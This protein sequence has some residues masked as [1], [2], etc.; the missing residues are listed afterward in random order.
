MSF[1]GG[2]ATG[3]G[4][5]SWTAP[6]RP[7][8]TVV[9]YICGRSYGTASLAIHTKACAKRFLEEEA[10][11]PKGQRRA[12][13]EPPSTELLAE[14]AAAQG[15][16]A[17]AGFGGGGAAAYKLIEAHNEAAFRQYN[18]VTLVACALCGRTFS[19]PDRLKIHNRSCTPDQPA[20][21]VG[22]KGVGNGGAPTAYKVE[23]DNEGA[24]RRGAALVGDEDGG[25]EDG[26][27]EAAAAAVAAAAAAA[28]AAAS[29]A[30]RRQGGGAGGARASAASQRSPPVVSRRAAEGKEEGG[31]G[32]G[33]GGGAP[34]ASSRGGGA[35]AAASAAATGAEEDAAWRESLEE[36]FALLRERLDESA[37]RAAREAAEIRAEIEELVEE[38]ARR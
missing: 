9:C 31:G 37:A 14:L 35:A 33:G 18:D 22:E 29:A 24:L 13:P 28:A 38:L 2:G 25:V 15:G 6:K 21:R 4:E 10:Q 26:E 19:G 7:P 1:G 11:K 12:L 5:T 32:G 17:G 23:A 30:Q 3:R 34:A 20:R 27:D 8:P 16:G 36:R